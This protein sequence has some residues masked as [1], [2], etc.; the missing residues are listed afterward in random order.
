MCCWK[1]PRSESLYWEHFESWRQRGCQLL[2][3]YPRER[4]QQDTTTPQHHPP[5]APASK[6]TLVEGVLFCR[7]APGTTVSI[8]FV[9]PRIRHTIATTRTGIGTGIGGSRRQTIQ[10]RGRTFVEPCGTSLLPYEET[11]ETSDETWDSGVIGVQTTTH[12]SGLCGCFE[13][14]SFV[15]K[16][17]GSLNYR[18]IYW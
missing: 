7:P 15:L 3:T 2:V 5:E 10:G 8:R 16:C 12:T 11:K 14:I 1:Q 4:K 6:A 17:M 9:L 13:K 18:W